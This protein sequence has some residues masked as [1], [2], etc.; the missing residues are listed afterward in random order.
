MCSMCVSSSD[1]TGKEKDE[2]TGYGY[3]GARYMDH[4]LM[5]MWL[6]VDPMTDK[7]PSISPYNYCI[8]NP[9]VLVDPDGFLPR[10]YVETNGI[11]HAFVSVEVNGKL[12]VYTYGRYLG[13]DKNKSKCN[14]LDP[15]GKGVL[16]RLTG[17][18]ARKYIDHKVEK[19]DASVYE[20]SD[21][22]NG[23]FLEDSEDCCIF[24]A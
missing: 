17:A 4:E 15:T 6:S 3:F 11:G 10:I 2:E 18:D 12:I 1:S 16:V 21:S 19:L 22:P 24:A 7:Y 20:F 8:W 14:S 13:G 9:V 23:F 5:T